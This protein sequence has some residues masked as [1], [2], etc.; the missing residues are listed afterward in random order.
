M[1]TNTGA[2]TIAGQIYSYYDNI[3][4][5]VYDLIN[6]AYAGCNE[7]NQH[8]VYIMKFTTPTFEGV[9]QSVDVGM[10]MYNNMNDRTAT[11][12]YAIC[13]SD[14]NKINYIN[15]YP[16]SDSEIEEQLNKYGQGGSVNL[17]L[18][19][20]VDTSV[21]RDAGWEDVGDG[22]ATVF[23]CTFSNEVG[24]VAM[25]FT[26][27]I[28]DENGDYQGVLSPEELQEYAEG[29]IAETRQ[30][31]LNLQIGAKFEGE[32]A[33]AEAEYAAEQIH[34]LQDYYYNNTDPTEVE[35]ENQI[36]TG[37]VTFNELALS[38]NEL[39]TNKEI[40][41]F[42]IETNDVRPNTTYYLFLWTYADTGVEILP[43]KSD[44]YG[45][46][47]VSV[48]YNSGVIHIW[49][50]NEWGDYLFYIYNQVTSEWELYIP[51]V[52]N[53]VTSSWDICS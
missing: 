53:E 6:P 14:E 1:A 31:D 43:V 8:Y 52:Y 38:R 23:T 18:R 28:A 12:R 27:I 17:T 49:D 34:K 15:I 22:I 21:L 50:E 44:Y 26:P 35:D 32:N 4:S 20:E 51:Y 37:T 39:A 13:S 16:M 19:P 40:Q 48:G 42:S 25:N 24:N 36:A 33:I 46:H 7:N 45:D 29:V 9:S 41:T 11:L 47:T 2:A 30:D 10:W 3:T 5:K